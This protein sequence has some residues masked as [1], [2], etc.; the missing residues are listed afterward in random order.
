MP[1]SLTVSDL[2]HLFSSFKPLGIINR[3]SYLD[4]LLDRLNLS[5]SLK[6]KYKSLSVG[7][8]RKVSLLLAL[9]NKPELILLD[10]P[11]AGLDDA[12]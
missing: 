8:K 10:E 6:K 7:T 2:I 11:V 3:A 12:S 9:I 4:N 1:P 5:G